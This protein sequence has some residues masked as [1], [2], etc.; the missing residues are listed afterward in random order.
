MSFREFLSR[1]AV[2]LAFGSAVSIMLSIA[3]SQIFLGLALAALLLSGDR[4]RLPRIQWAFAAFMVG[5]LISMAFSGEPAHALPQIRKFYLYVGVLL[6]V[7]SCL[8]DV[9]WIRW[10]FLGW[11]GLGSLE[12][13]RGFV[14]F[15]SK[16]H[17]AHVA[18]QNFY[19]FYVSSR[20][21]GFTSHWNTY[22]GKEMFAIVMLLAFL[23]FSPDACKRIWVWIGSAV[24]V[25]VA[26]LLS[27]TRGVWIA[28]FAAGLYLV[29]YWNKK[30]ILAV[31]VAAVAIFLLS[32]PAIRQRFT[33]ILRPR[34]EDSNQFR[35]VA[36]RTGLHMIE[37]HPWL[38]LGPDGP[39][40][41]FLEYIPAD[42]PRPLP[43]GFYEHLHNVY[44]QYAADR[45]I[46]TAL[47]FLWILIQIPF[48]F[49]RGLRRLPPGRDNRRFLLHGG[50]AVV[51]AAMVEGFVEVNLGDSEV[52]TMFLVVVACGYV[53]LEKDA[54]FGESLPAADNLAV[55]RP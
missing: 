55:K 1:S 41:H 39:R 47:A 53:A 21:T 30:L 18:G 42:I 9:K 2:W 8:R 27:D 28:V 38:G 46:P 31:P 24:L 52:L 5:T 14:Q 51:I 26:I 45:G 16:V 34:Q 37:T 10:V 4:M 7:F 50:I 19:E 20:I 48:D 6:V 23:F 13:L 3:V 33:S 43:S 54:V 17:D 49:W 44:L 29:W 15:A 22:A 12:A 32:P 36:W 40:Y 11:A 25:T 35:I